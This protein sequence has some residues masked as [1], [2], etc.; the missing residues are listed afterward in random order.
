MPKVKQSM[1]HK[2]NNFVSRYGE[3]VFST[4]GNI[5]FCKLCEVRVA[6]EKKFTIDQHVKREKHIRGLQ[7]LE[8]KKTTHQMLLGQACSSSGSPF[9]EELC[10][11]FICADIPLNKVNNP[12]LRAFLEKHTGKPIPDS[13]TLRKNYV[14]RCYQRTMQEIRQKVSGKKIWVCMDES[15]DSLG[16]YVANVVVGTMEEDGSGEQFLINCEQLEKVNFSTISKVFDRSLGLIY[17]NGIQHDSVLLLLTDA[18]P[19]MVKAANSLQALYSKMVHVTCL[20][21]ALHRVAESVS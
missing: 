9:F 11:A 15:T 5:L 1:A 20:A 10:E 4:D 17:P 18:A 14:S 21:H 6:A 19:Y 8:G 16:R 2:L 13:S 7:L 12:K 3:K